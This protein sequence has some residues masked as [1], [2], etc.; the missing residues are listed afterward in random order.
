MRS[1]GKIAEL[2][3]EVQS[4]EARAKDALD[5]AETSKQSVAQL[6]RECER[7][8]ALL[9]ERDGSDVVRHMH[10]WQGLPP[11]M[12]PN[13]GAWPAGQMP[14]PGPPPLMAPPALPLPIHGHH[15]APFMQGQVTFGDF[16]AFLQP[17]PGFL[18]GQGV[19]PGRAAIPVGLANSSPSPQAP[20]AQAPA[21]HAAAEN[22]PPPVE[23]NMLVSIFSR[24]APS[25]ADPT[26]TPDVLLARVEASFLRPHSWVPHYSNRYGSVRDFILAHPEEFAVTG[27]GYVFRRPR[28]PP[29]QMMIT[30]LPPPVQG[31]LNFR[32]GPKPAAAAEPAIAKETSGPAADEPG[33]KPSSRGRTNGQPGG[34]G[35]KP[36]GG[37]GGGRPSDF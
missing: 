37:R 6:L 10:D 3:A 35:R 36:A 4:A 16:P 8:N 21:A 15:E 12:L 1:L 30:P 14:W 5:T 7:L 9:R 27:E 28:T 2:N 17:P 25:A 22:A 33:N 32:D 31:V 20:A 34:R 23:E 11:H 24:A 26:V 13:G 19:P 18:P 29:L